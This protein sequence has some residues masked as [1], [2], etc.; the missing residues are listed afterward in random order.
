MC[1]CNVHQGDVTPSPPS[2]INIYSGNSK[3]PAGAAKLRTQ[4]CQRSESVSITVIASVGQE[5]SVLG[6][7]VTIKY[8]REKLADNLILIIVIDF[9]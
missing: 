3:P 5:E 2:L 8:H 6:L 1:Q 7:A 9:N 4:P